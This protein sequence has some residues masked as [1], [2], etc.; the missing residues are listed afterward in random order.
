MVFGSGRV[1]ADMTVS[2]FSGQGKKQ[3]FTF[4]ADTQGAGKPPAGKQAAARNAAIAEALA[5][6]KAPPEKLSANVEAPAR[7][8]GRAVGEK[9]VAYAK[10][11]GWLATAGGR[12]SSIS[13]VTR[14]AAGSGAAGEV[15]GSQARATIRQETASV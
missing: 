14:S 2:T 8:L 7:R 12:P 10:E 11:Q 4:I 1:S 5:A 15:A 9:I 6:Q 3:L 13:G